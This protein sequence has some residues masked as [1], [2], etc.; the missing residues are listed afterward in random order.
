MGH[1]VISNCILLDQDRLDHKNTDSERSRYLESFNRA[2]NMANYGPTELF[3]SNFVGIQDELGKL[4]GAHGSVL[5]FWIS[6]KKGVRA[7]AG[8][9]G[10]FGVVR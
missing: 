2:S 1:T 7:P 9:S 3:V 10:L 8:S 6:Q 4:F 5:D